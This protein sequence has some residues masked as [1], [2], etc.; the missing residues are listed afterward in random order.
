MNFKLTWIKT[1]V[2]IV[3]GILMGLFGYKIKYLAA[4]FAW[5][6]LIASV[7][8]FIILTGII[9]VIWS[10]LQGEN[11]WIGFIVLALIVML[12]I[13][14][15]VTYNNNCNQAFCGQ[16]C[17]THAFGVRI[18]SEIKNCSSQLQA[19]LVG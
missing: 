7:F 5:Y 10:L 18:Y 6:G 2:A 12:I 9:Y 17:E 13:I 19:K 16:S 1:I 11:K 8:Y 3:A 14:G 4:D 15:I